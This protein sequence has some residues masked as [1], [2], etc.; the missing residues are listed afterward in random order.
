[1]KQIFNGQKIKKVFKK[2]VAAGLLSLLILNYAPQ[3]EAQAATLTNTGAPA[4]FELSTVATGLIVPTGAAF[5]PDGRLF[6]IQKNGVVKIYKNGVLLSQPFYT[7]ANVNNYVDRGLLGL[8]LDPNFAVNGYVYLL[9]TYDNNPSNL[10]GPKTGRL[11]RVS[12][13]GDTAVAGSEVTILGTNI[14]NS[15][16]TSCDDFAVTSDCLPADSLSH[17][18][19]SIRFAPDG[20]LF[21]SVGDGAGYDDVDIKALRSQNLDSLAGKILRINT[22]G[23]APTDNPFYNGNPN[24]NRSKVWSYGVRNSFRINVR[25]SDGEVFLGEVGWNTWEEINHAKKGANLGWPC[26]EALEQ[27]NGDGQPAHGKY[28]DLP[29]CQALYQNPGSNLQFPIYYYAHPP[30]SS[31]IGGLFYTGTNY[32][33]QYQNVYFFGDYS[34]NQIYNLKVDANNNLVPGSVTTFASNVGGP[35]DF[36]KGPAGDIYYIAINTG[37]INKISYSSGNL[38]PTAIASSDKQFGA[39]PLSVNFSSAGSSDPE[40]DP[41]SFAWNFGDGTAVSNLANPNHVFAANGSYTATLTVTDTHNN[42]STAN[43]S[44]SVGQGAPLVNITAPANF[45]RYNSGDTV[46]FSATAIDPEDGTLSGNSLVWNVYVHHCPLNDCHIHYLVSSN[47]NS[48]SF[49]FPEHDKPFYIEISLTA[50]DSSGLATTKSISVYPYGEEINHSLIFD[51]IND[52]AEITNSQGLFTQQLTAQAWIKSLST[53]TWGGEVISAGNNWGLRLLTDGNVRFFFNST[54]GWKNYE[55][56]GVNIKDGVWHHVTAS[57]GAANVKLYVDGILKATFASPEAINYLYGQKVIIGKHGD[58]DDNFTF[59]GSIDEVQLWGVQR[60]DAE[61]A[62]TYNK[63]I[64]PQTSLLTYLRMEDGAGTNA[65]DLSGNG[66]DATL[67]NG[68][69]WTVGVPLQALATVN[70]AT[71]FN[72]GSSASVTNTGDLKLQQFTAE[73]WVKLS[74]TG[75]YGGEIMSLGN[76]FGLRVNWDGNIRFFTRTTTA[77]VDLQTNNVNILDNTWH[78]L[79]VTRSTGQTIIYLDGVVKLTAANVSPI[80]YNLGNNLIFGKHGDGDINFNLNGTIDETRFW[81]SVRTQAEINSAKGVDLNPQTSGLLAYLKFNEGLGQT[82]AD[83]TNFNHTA[84]L[85]TPATWVAGVTLNQVNASVGFDGINDQVQ[86]NGLTVYKSQTLTTEAWF[87]STAVGVYGG[88]VISA[89]NNWG[90]RLLPDGNLRYFFHIGN[91]VWRNFETTGI[92]LKGNGWHHVAVTKDNASVKIY[93]DGVLKSTFV[94]AEAISY[95]LGQNL[96]IG[97]HGDADNQFN[98]TGSIDEVRLWNSVRTAAEI[99]A[100]YNKEIAVNSAGLLGYWKFND[101]NGLVSLDSS[102]NANSASLQNGAS[103]QTGSPLIP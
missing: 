49:V 53:D 57:K 63:I 62:Q 93:V 31:A 100:S 13:A 4:G 17:A 29:Q 43:V 42:Q 59:N 99:S 10:G 23:T 24:A 16:Q 18:P 77:W 91:F 92:N 26:Y 37:S 66:R 56:T 7:I 14:G 67:Q 47:N 12:A 71:S 60:T 1:M 83:V 72:N 96:I 81:S 94:N 45:S 97:R 5:A 34:K 89:G 87:N 28:K 36:L 51:G 86:I 79:A 80:A 38:A 2:A 103:W 75:N 88:E 68:T 74:G 90:I 46:N 21:V 27:Q 85:S 69:N 84:V 95:T 65:T 64:L 3:K 35:V 54:A 41:L 70:N 30:S 55:T 9:F 50:T 48:G 39:A 11:I 25:E 40:N 101:N 6:I 82:V 22:N 33:A 58:L 98:F 61:V 15:V 19:G 20:K 8:A 76:N 32:P 44:I 73:T 52:S 102:T 78:H